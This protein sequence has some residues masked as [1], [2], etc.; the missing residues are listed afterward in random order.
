MERKEFIR[1]IWIATGIV[2]LVMV[3][4]L[5]VKTTFNVFLLVLAGLL[6]AIYFRG[7]SGL[8]CRYTKRKSGLCLTLSVLVTTLLIAGLFWMIGAKVAAQAQELS[9]KIPATVDNAKAYLSQSTMGR[10]I[11]SRLSSPEAMKQAESIARSFFK[12]SFGLLGDIYIVL[13]LGIFFTVSPQLY[14]KGIL[15]IVPRAGK[16]KAGEVLSILANN[17][18]KWLKGK[19]FAM[20]VVFVLTAAGLLLIGV[21]LWLV[22]ALIAGLLNFIPNFGPLLAL[23]PAVLVALMISPVTAAIVAGLY[24]FIQVLESNVITPMV[25]Q[26]LIN[27]PPALIIIAQL[28]ISPLTGVWG[29]LLATPLMLITITLVQEL[30]LK[31]Q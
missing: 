14:V 21:P 30:Y 13:F 11:M 16:E 26:R 2:A 24:I 22:L 7:L 3:I 20:L 18:K 5:L 6:I 23:V 8:I 27:I 25:Q 1:R 15:A 31:K 28:L 10:E 29:L 17:L 12:S 9:E 4:L 19:L